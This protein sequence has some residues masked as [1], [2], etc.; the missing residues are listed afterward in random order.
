MARPD[1]KPWTLEDFLRWEEQQS[2]KYEF[3]DGVVY[4]MAGGTAEHAAITANVIISLGTQLRGRPCQPYTSD[5]KVIAGQ[6]SA[7]PDVSVGCMKLPRRATEYDTPV[8]IVEVLSRTTRPRD[9]GGKWAAY[10]RLESL[11]HYVLVEP[12]IMEVEVRSRADAWRPR[13]YKLAEDAIELPEIGARLTLK[14]IY[15]KI[16]L[17]AA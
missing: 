1:P 6:I 3:V 2:D 8:V 13:V 11:R 5:M 4:A 14:E 15:D 10:R 16:D 17:D 12:E 7:Y 9:I